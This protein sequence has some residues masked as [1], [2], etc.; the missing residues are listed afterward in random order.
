MNLFSARMPASVFT[1]MSLF[2]VA[3][4]VLASKNLPPSLRKRSWNMNCAY[5]ASRKNAAPYTFG[6]IFSVMKLP[7]SA[8][9]AQV[10]GTSISRLYLALNASR[11]A[12]SAKMSLR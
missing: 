7:T 12:G 2:T 3:F 1:P 6:A 8:K 4:M 5:G 10:F 11:S 9:S